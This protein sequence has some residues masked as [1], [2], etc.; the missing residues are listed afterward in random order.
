M[1]ADSEVPGDPTP[2]TKRAA[3]AHRIT[4][5]DVAQAAGVSVATV[6]KVVNERYGVNPDTAEMVREVI[7]RLGYESSLIASSLRRIEKGHIGVLLAGFEP[8][9]AEVLKGISAEAVGKG[10]E[11]LAYSGAIADAN[12]VGWERRSIARLGGTLIDGAIVLT[13]TVTLPNA[14]I[15]VVAID[16][17]ADAKDDTCFIDSDNRLGAQL[18]TEHL[19]GLGHRRIAHISG[20]LDLE[21]GIERI[22]GYRDALR[23]ASLPDDDLVRPGD[24][25]ADRSAEAAREL[26]ALVP[27]PTA[28]FAA[29][30]QS[31]FGVLQVAS[32]LGL[33]VP[34]DLS[35]VGYDNV[36]ES[37]VSSPPLTTVAQPLWQMG[38]EAVK[39]LL[40]LLAGEPVTTHRRLPTSLIVRASTAEHRPS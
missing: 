28:I 21:S 11:L 23:T 36:L 35:V 5:S 26:L 4:I 13:P 25:R 8:Y 6:S 17:H 9:T 30:D 14:S 37:S 38:A 32:E 16:P 39:M 33:R 29:N 24:Y 19:I 34:E 1:N 22:A 3:P 10:Y 18:A 15:P 40:T 2:P 20:R 7:A 12:A 27:R 31:A